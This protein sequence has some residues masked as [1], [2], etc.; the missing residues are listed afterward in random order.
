ME[1]SS[2]YFKGFVIGILFAICLTTF[3]C[4]K[5]KEVYSYDLNSFKMEILSKNVSSNASATQIDFDDF[6]YSTNE[7]NSCC[8][9]SISL[10]DGESNNCTLDGYLGEYVDLISSGNDGIIAV[11]SFE[12]EGIT[13]GYYFLSVYDS[14]GNQLTL[15]VNLYELLGLSG[16]PVL[17]IHP[18]S[19]TRILISTDKEIIVLDE[20]CN[21]LDRKSF[22]T[23][24]E[25]LF[26]HENSIAVN[27]LSQKNL[28]VYY[29]SDLKKVKSI[30]I[31]A[32]KN[33]Y[34][35]VNDSFYLDDGHVFFTF[36]RSLCLYTGNGVEELINF[37]D[38]CIE[39]DGISRDVAIRVEDGG[40][41]EIVA[42][43]NLEV[44][45][46]STQRIVRFQSYQNDKSDA[47]EIINLGVFGN[48]YRVIPFVKLFN[49]ASE[50]YYINCISLFENEESFDRG[51]YSSSEINKAIQKLNEQ[52]VD[53][54]YFDMDYMALLNTEEYVSNEELERVLL[55]EDNSSFY[56]DL[57]FSSNSGGICP[58]YSIS[59]FSV[60]ADLD[61]NMGLLSE[62]D[63]YSAKCVLE[64]ILNEY[65]MNRTVIEEE[66]V[67][68]LMKIV[69]KYQNSTS[70]SI[71]YYEN[72][73]MDNF[74]DS[75]L[76][77]NTNLVGNIFLGRELP[78]INS[79][80]EYRVNACSMNLDGCYAFLRFL[81][82][83]EL[84]GL[85]VNDFCTFSV[86]K[87]VC[88]MQAEEYYY[89]FTRKM[90]FVDDIRLKE[91]FYTN[92][93]VQEFSEKWLAFLD[94]ILDRNKKDLVVNGIVCE[95]IDEWYLS[96]RDDLACLEEI[97]TRTDR[98]LDE[99]QN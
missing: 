82:Q 40:I 64:E 51:Y 71:R 83:P 57:M 49:L 42:I 88:S 38:Y 41:I 39:S 78:A 26:V 58:F 13:Y 97:L 33:L 59:A 2:G 25:N 48:S 14:L 4:S 6:S 16:T 35:E 12:Q 60:N 24:I 67:L 76:N 10:Q 46:S 98:Y 87:D 81:L 32:I 96:D 95:V 66:M 91:T 55:G 53:L 99:A 86:N 80:G 22:E 69:K 85:M 18:L 7:A 54:F 27:T 9:T 92:T 72:M 45:V 28:I 44:M 21:I 73:N 31:D 74:C 94:S 90:E 17:E 50:D 77:E 19:K 15:N 61:L 5:S 3:G 37:D 8:F 1:K 52:S 11:L 68:D 34:G 84:S 79:M 20:R 36:S 47:R 75:L 93:S 23:V 65:C 56:T 63:A 30:D 29:D 62:L 89:M 70:E 43:V